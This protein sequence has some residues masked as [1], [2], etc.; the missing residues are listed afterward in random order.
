[1]TRKEERM[2][3]AC[4]LLDGLIGCLKITENWQ[5]INKNLLLS[6]LEEVRELLEK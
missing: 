4:G 5:E 3:R 6:A 1:M 2:A